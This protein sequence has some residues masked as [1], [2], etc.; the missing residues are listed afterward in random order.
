MSYR[1]IKYEVD[2]KIATIT[3][4]RPDKLN[5]IND[6]MAEEVLQALEAS[7][8]DTNVNVVLIRGEGGNFSAGV[9]LKEV[10]DLPKPI[11]DEPSEAW[12]EHLDEMVDVSMKM[13]SHSKPVIAIAEGFALGGAAD[14]VLSADIVIATDD[15][16][17]GE[18]EVRFGSAPPT[19]MMPWVVGIKKTKELLFTG[20]TIDAN[21]ALNYGIYNKVVSKEELDETIKVMTHKL[22]HIPPSVLRITKKSIN[23]VYEMQNLR[24]SI[25]YNL[26]AALAI[27]FLLTEDEVAQIKEDIN[28]KGLGGFLAPINQV[29][30]KY[31]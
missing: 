9:D 2:E 18:P 28:T 8:Q 20:D 4:N 27:F 19:L 7:D 22:A 15:A 13:W 31:D 16:K 5:A 11:G 24:E 17:F 6:V 30:E 23:K 3:L 1:T 12:R 21:E 29:F 14:W 25:D 26:E 10:F